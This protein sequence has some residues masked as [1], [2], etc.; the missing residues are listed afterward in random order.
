MVVNGIKVDN[1]A[2]VHTGII[3]ETDDIGVTIEVAGCMGII[4]MPMRGLICKNNPKIGDEVVFLMSLMEMKDDDYE[5]SILK[6][7]GK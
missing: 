3:T 1:T 4:K 2:K 5:D 7:E 6:R